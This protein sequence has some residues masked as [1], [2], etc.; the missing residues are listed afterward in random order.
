MNRA[1]PEERR[2]V[3]RRKGS[4]AARWTVLLLGAV[5]LTMYV[6][7]PMWL[8][9]GD[10]TR[11]PHATS[12]GDAPEVTALERAGFT[13]AKENGHDPDGEYFTQYAY[14]SWSLPDQVASIAV[15]YRLDKGP[16]PGGRGMFRSGSGNIS[17]HL[18]EV[19]RQGEGSGYE[20]TVTS[21]FGDESFE[22]VSTTANLYDPSRF[23]MQA[24]RVH[25]VAIT[26]SYLDQDG[27]DVEQMR[28]TVRGLAAAA[29]ERF[30]GVNP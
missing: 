7:L 25:N 24:V 17:R 12:V 18:A 20:T 30:H 27:A 19:R 4:R 13:L 23:A 22:Q 21:G 2:H 1:K 9:N 8:T 6:F 3:T 10:L 26:V 14:A 5:A 29:V 16:A 28:R 15:I 11:V